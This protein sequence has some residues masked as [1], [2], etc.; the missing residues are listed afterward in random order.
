MSL[1]IQTTSNKAQFLNYFSDPII[2]PP[3]STIALNKVACRIPVWV[4]KVIRVPEIELVRRNDECL[5]I[6]IN[7]VEILITWTNLFTAHTSFATIDIEAGVS[8]DNYFSGNFEYFA[9]NN[10]FLIPSTLIGQSKQ[11]IPFV[12]VLAKAIDDKLEFYECLP[13]PVYKND[14]VVYNP[15]KQIDIGGTNYDLLPNADSLVELGFQITYAP[16][17]VFNSNPTIITGAVSF[18][19]LINTTITTDAVNGDTIT[20][21]SG[22]GTTYLSACA[23]NFIIDTNGGY[24][25]FKPNVNNNPGSVI[26]GFSKG[27]NQNYIAQNYITEFNIGDIHFGIKFNDST[28]GAGD[29]HCFQ[30]IDGTSKNVY[31][32]AANS[33]VP[34]IYPQTEFITFN[35]NSDYFYISVRRAL[36]YEHNSNE[37]IF[38]VYIASNEDVTNS[39][40][41]YQSDIFLATPNMPLIPIICANKNMTDVIKENKYIEVGNDTTDMGEYNRTEAIGYCNKFTISALTSEISGTGT[42]WTPDQLLRIVDFWKAWGLS[43]LVE[44]DFAIEA[45]KGIGTFSK[46]FRIKID[47]FGN[48]AGWNINSIYYS[49]GVPSKSEDNPYIQANQAVVELYKYDPATNLFTINATAKEVIDTL[50]DS[51]NLYIN[52]LPIKNYSGAPP[53]M[54][55]NQSLKEKLLGNI[56]LVDYQDID[57]NTIWVINYEVFNNLYRPLNNPNPLN[58]NQING[59]LSYDISIIRHIIP[60]LDGLLKVD[61]NVRSQGA[62][63][64]PQNNLL[65]YGR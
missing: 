51:L 59:E 54:N 22:T 5:R 24:W 65:S 62:P 61:M 36:T 63:K 34:K 42:P 47:P 9:N 33:D 25:R 17:N 53:N 11:K 43:S 38:Q 13:S 57:A 28:G 35:N 20:T 26:C 56:S 18:S 48:P 37:Y 29:H 14:E 27:G 30:I 4:Q 8:A 46:T 2:I 7:G 52:D 49:I 1:N 15:L 32:G 50:P 41:V 45:N 40:L 31:N 64:P 58:V 12:N 23:G 10:V 39:V 6:N 16:K 3:N 55:I 19:N 44:N 60:N 21:N